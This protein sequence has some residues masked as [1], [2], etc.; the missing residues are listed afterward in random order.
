MRIREI[1]CAPY[2]HSTHLGAHMRILR[3][4]IGGARTHMERDDPLVAWLT[5][6]GKLR[7]SPV[8]LP[9]PLDLAD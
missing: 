8:P 6:S 9:G 4:V 3:G 1:E 5:E 7:Q 2:A